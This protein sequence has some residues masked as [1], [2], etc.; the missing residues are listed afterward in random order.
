MTLL[1]ELLTKTLAQ[2][3]H[4]LSVNW[5]FLLASAVIAAALKLYVN[6]DRVA[7][8]LQRNRKAGV[9]IAT[10]AAVGTPLC[11]CGTTAVILGM[12]A[13][14]MPWAPII[15]FMVASP[16]TSPQELV[17]SAGLFGWNFALAFFL[18]SILLGLVGGAAA[19][20]LESRGW[21]AGQAR[22]KSIS[23]A[24]G[25]TA[26][27]IQAKPHVTLNQFLNETWLAGKRLALFFLG[28]AFI[29]YLLNNL[30]P[31]QWISTLFGE[32]QVYGVPLAAILGIPFYFN[33]EASLPL[34]RALMDAG[35]SQGAVLAF[36]VTG[37]GTSIGAIAGALTIARWRVVALVV[38]TLLIG[39]TAFGYGYNILL[40][41]L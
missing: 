15:A 14:N 21:L 28:F 26:P 9:V 38:A 41:V 12:M 19:H 36:L 4:T 5:I 16:L 7:A 39:A 18:A 11:S 33:T 22:F 13:G 23:G 6:Q 27:A 32:G 35:M 24:S 17:F 1:I 30:I 40:G 29:G 34:A 31:S 20:L 10:G 2:V 37:A 8:F 25:L 3:W